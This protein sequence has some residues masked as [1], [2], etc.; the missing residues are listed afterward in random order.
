MVVVVDDG[1]VG[2]VGPEV[3]VDV[4]FFEQVFGRGLVTWVFDGNGVD[5]VVGEGVFVLAGNGRYRCTTPTWAFER[6]IADG[7]VEPL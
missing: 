6:E 7:V 1:V 5:V 4:G 2:S 3:E